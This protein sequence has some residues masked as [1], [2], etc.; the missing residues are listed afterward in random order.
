MT[1]KLGKDIS[2]IIIEQKEENSFLEERS[3]KQTIKQ[4]KTMDY[5]IKVKS[6]DSENTTRGYYLYEY[7]GA[8]QITSNKDNASKFRRS[9]VESLA[10][11]LRSIYIDRSFLIEEYF[12]SNEE[13]C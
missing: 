11:K 12:K 7:A 8:L 6:G 4:N 9:F 3:T 2:Q 1:S 13:K 10:K 5:I